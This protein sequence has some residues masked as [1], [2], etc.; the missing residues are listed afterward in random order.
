MVEELVK[1]R[2]RLHKGDFRFDASP[3]TWNL[4]YAARPGVYQ[5]DIIT[6]YRDSEL[7]GY[8]VAC[9]SDSESEDDTQFA[10]LEEL[11]FLL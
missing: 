1:L 4:N 6:V 5:D 2:N 8:A 10:L 11:G 7:K 9:L 3:D